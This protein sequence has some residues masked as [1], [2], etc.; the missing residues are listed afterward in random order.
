MSRNPIR[1]YTATVHV[2]GKGERAILGFT[3][4]PGW[5]LLGTAW[6]PLHSEV[7]HAWKM[8]RLVVPCDDG[9]VKLFPS[10]VV[11]RAKLKHHGMTWEPA[12]GGCGPESSEGG[13]TS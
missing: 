5:R 3:G 7:V 8:T 12:P 4:H 6:A 10:E 2:A 1:I 9:D 13:H 11:E